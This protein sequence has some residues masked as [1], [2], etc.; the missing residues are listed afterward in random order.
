MV[1]A[2]GAVTGTSAS[3]IQPD[4]PTP[5]VGVWERISIATFVGRIAV[6]AI[7]LSRAP[8]AAATPNRRA[9]SGHDHER[10]QHRANH[11]GVRSWDSRTPTARQFW[12][13]GQLE[14]TGILRWE[15]PDY[16]RW[17][18][19]LLSV[20]N[21]GIR[22]PGLGA[23]RSLACRRRIRTSGWTRASTGCTVLAVPC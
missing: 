13:V 10:C 12:T 2:C 5:W 16:G 19:R 21:D 11:G 4:L 23:I 7:A 15:I 17:W 1:L 8:H 14:F 20:R 9:P 3:P 18:H 6:L 22:R